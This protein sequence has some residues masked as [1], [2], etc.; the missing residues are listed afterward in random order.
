[1]NKWKSVNILQKTMK[2]SPNDIFIEIIHNEANDFNE[3]AKH[4]KLKHKTFNNTD[5]QNIKISVVKK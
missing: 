1:M 2:L 5:D 4:N 3:E